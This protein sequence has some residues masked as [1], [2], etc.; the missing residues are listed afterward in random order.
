MAKNYTRDSSPDAKREK[1]GQKQSAYP[2]PKFNP[3][4]VTARQQSKT[5]SMTVEQ[6][7][8]R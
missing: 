3:T 7:S 4:E 1:M 2:D 8:N 5:Q 6:V